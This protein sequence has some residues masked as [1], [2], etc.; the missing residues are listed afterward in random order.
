MSKDKLS[1]FKNVV[2]KFI[3][4]RHHHTFTLIK[5]IIQKVILKRGQFIFCLNDNNMRHQHIA[6]HA[7]IRI[8]IDGNH[9]IFFKDSDV[10]GIISEQKIKE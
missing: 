5:G 7:D 6:F 10:F 8:D 4:T 9:N 2:G 1:L 3:T